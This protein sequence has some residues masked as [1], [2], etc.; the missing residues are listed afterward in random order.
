[1][2]WQPTWLTGA[3]AAVITLVAVGWQAIKA[4]LANPVDLLRDE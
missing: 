1:M 4:A 3:L 2:D